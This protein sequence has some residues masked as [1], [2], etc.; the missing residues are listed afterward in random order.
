VTDPMRHNLVPH[1]KKKGIIETRERFVKLT[2]DMLNS[3]AWQFLRPNSV[4][5]YIQILK[6]F[7]GHNNG[8]ISMSL[9]EAATAVKAGKQTVKAAVDQLVEYGFIKII[10]KGYFTGRKA[11]EYA[12]TDFRLD[13]RS[14]TREW[15]VWRPKRKHRRKQIPKIGIQTILD[16]L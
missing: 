14:P 2:Y 16:E 7:N 12:I 8:R 4:L 5:V 11:T 1:L 3:A 6:R 15:K 13:G 10:K 9:N